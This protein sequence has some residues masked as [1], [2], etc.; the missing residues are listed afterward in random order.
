MWGK[1]AVRALLHRAGMDIVPW[2]TGEWP[3]DFDEFDRTVIA[4]TKPYTMTSPERIVTLIDAV[5]YVARAKVPGAIIE[6]GVWK[7]GSMMATAMTLLR[8]GELRDLYLYDTFEGMTEPTSKDVDVFGTTAKALLARQRRGED[9]M[10]FWAYAPLDKVKK[11]L[12]DTGYPVDRTH[13]VVGRVEDT[14]PGTTP[15][16]IALLRLDTDWYQSTQ[17]ELEHLYPLLAPQGVLIIDDYGHHLGARQA[18]D[19]YFQRRP[20]LLCRVDYTGRLAIKS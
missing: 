6:C 15:D 9:A 14:I 19:E 10:N 3:P 13:F 1:R 11:A 20:L 8:V 18:T 4:K 2:P 16:Q 5:E 17:H 12:G 7:G